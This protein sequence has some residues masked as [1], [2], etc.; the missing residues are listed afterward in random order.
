LIAYSSIID[1]AASRKAVLAEPELRLVSS[2]V[3]MP[4]VV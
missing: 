1:E 4:R 2:Q 3:K